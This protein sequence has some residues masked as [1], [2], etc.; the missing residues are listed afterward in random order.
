MEWL[1]VVLSEGVLPDEI[2]AEVAPAS[3]VDEVN[4][5]L[6]RRRA[7]MEKQVSLDVIRDHE[8]DRITEWYEGESVK[9]RSAVGFIDRALDGWAR[10]RFRDDGVQTHNLPFGT[11]RLRKARTRVV[12]DG[13]AGR[14]LL[15]WAAGCVRTK[16]EVEKKDVLAAVEAGPDSGLAIGRKIEEFDVDG[17][18]YARHAVRAV[19]LDDDDMV[20]EEEDVEGLTVEVPLADGRTMSVQHTPDE[21]D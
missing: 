1:D 16:Y 12:A 13:D 17:V 5:L 18:R 3:D 15:G 10:A 11:I 19:V 6:R 8:R 9:L 14:N 20:V 2:P 4:R 21:I 7:L